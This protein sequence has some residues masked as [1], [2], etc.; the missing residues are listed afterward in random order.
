MTRREQRP[1]WFFRISS[2]A[3]AFALALFALSLAAAP[4]APAQTY[5]VLHTFYDGLDSGLPYGA[6]TMDRAG[7]LY[8]TADW[9]F[10]CMGLEYCYG[11]VFKLSNRGQ[12]WTFT[13]LYSFAGGADGANPFAGVTIGPDGALY[14]TTVNG[15]TYNYGTVFRLV[16]GASFCRNVSCQW[17]KT[18]LHSFGG[19]NDGVYPYGGLTFDAAGNLYGTTAGGPSGPGSVFKLTR[20][21]NSWTESVLWGFSGTDGAN[22]YGNLVLDSAGNIYGTNFDGGYSSCYLGCGTVF[23]LTPNG[24]S[25][26]ESILH[27]FQGGADGDGPYA[28]LTFDNSGN[29]Y[30][31]TSANGPI[32]GGTVFELT[33]SNGGWTYSVAY[34]LPG[35][36]SSEFPNPG[37][38]GSLIVGP[39]GNLY[40]T[41]IMNG[42]QNLGT[43]FMLMPHNDGYEYTVLYN[44]C[45]DGYPCPEGAWPWA[46]V[47]RDSS[48]NLYGTGIAGGYYGG[49][50]RVGGCGMV[51]ELTP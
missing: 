32:G 50:C 41:T 27:Y 49:N 38:R 33:A 18:T 19:P 36:T 31:V 2:H 9:S 14:G 22:P 51:F 29:L 24:N 26:T 39:A 1:I 40:G 8:G 25:W 23:E 17:V 20:Y 37:P 13:A 45:A 47:I 42:S 48:G 6:L 5:T 44:F 43:V 28:G 3:L 21:G 11:L 30:G 15:G 7:N 34:G 4:A 16:P 35:E 10:E 12:G 46:G